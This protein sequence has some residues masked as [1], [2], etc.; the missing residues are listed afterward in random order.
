MAS[1]CAGGGPKLLYITALALDMNYPFLS[2]NS[3]H[4]VF[5]QNK[6]GV[7]SCLK[8]KDFQIRYRSANM[9]I[10]E[11]QFQLCLNKLQ[12]DNLFPFSRMKMVCIHCCEKCACHLESQL[13]L[14]KYAIQVVEETNFLGFYLDRKLSF[15]PHLRYVKKKGIKFLYKTLF[16][17][18]NTMW[19][20]SASIDLCCDPN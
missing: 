11:Y 13:E 4:L 16:I 1:H 8:L 6:P 18:L 15:I 9:N 7:D 19:L 20:C 12:Q 14:D 10:I 3:S 17:T 2:L 5:C